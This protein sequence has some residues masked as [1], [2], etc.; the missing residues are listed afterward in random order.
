MPRSSRRKRVL[1]AAKQKRYRAR[2][3]NGFRVIEFEADPTDVVDLLH[4]AGV[5]VPDA[6][7]ATLGRCLVVLLELW[8]EGRLRVV[9]L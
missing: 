1:R 2:H 6:D 9:R 7:A 4:E 8:N 5:F 3:A